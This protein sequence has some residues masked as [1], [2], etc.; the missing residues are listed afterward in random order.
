M[1]KTDIATLV[2]IER[3]R[4]FARFRAR[5]LAAVDAVNTGKHAKLQTPLEKPTDEKL[6]E[7]FT[8]GESVDYWRQFFSDKRLTVDYSAGLLMGLDPSQVKFAAHVK[9]RKI[10]AKNWPPF[11]IAVELVDA[12]TDLRGHIEVALRKND[13]YTD[14]DN[15]LGHDDLIEWAKG[16]CFVADEV[17]VAW[18]AY[19][20]AKEL[21]QAE[22]AY[23]LRQ[24]KAQTVQAPALAPPA[25]QRQNERWKAC[26]DAG[27]TMPKDTYA[28]YPR[29]L[30][31]VA[32]SLGIK[33][34]SLREDLDKYRERVFGN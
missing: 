30:K 6:F 26:L 25:A 19:K 10:P 20:K 12:F 14:K 11:G 22:K 13:L 28:P 34:Q 15:K 18:E 21:E 33:R 16:K 4:Q 32:E 1:R 17:L 24:V 2:Q 8:G 3:H 27:M 31:K 9:E 23:E 29:G 7:A 5:E